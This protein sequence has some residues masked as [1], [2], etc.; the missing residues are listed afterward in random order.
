MK[1]QILVAVCALATAQPFLARETATTAASDNSGITNT[2]GQLQPGDT[3]DS[4][5]GTEAPASRWLT[6][7]TLSFS[8]RWR[9]VADSHGYHLFDAGQERALIDGKLKLDGE[10][11]Y[12]VN[13]HVST[14]RYF[15]WAYADSIGAGF[16]STAANSLPY[17]S[18][19]QLANLYAAFAADPKGYADFSSHIASRGWR[20]GVR[21]FYF[22]GTPIKQITFEYG[23]LGIERGANTE[24]TSY[25]EDG[26]L[27]GERLRIKDPQ[28]LFF[29]QVAVTYGYMGDYFTPNFF[30]RADRLTQSNYHQFLVDKRFGRRFKAS[31]D[32][33]WENRTDTIR[34]AV[35]VKMPET[36][37]LD[38]AR[39][40][41]YQRVN[42]VTLQGETFGSG[43]GFAITGS[44]NIAKR[45]LLEGGYATIDRSYAALAGDRVIATGFAFNGDSWGLGSR[46]YT[47]ANLK[48]ND[49][50]TL[51]G[52]YTHS[53]NETYY[54]LTRQG[55][56][57]G[58]TV[59]FKNL[60]NNKLHLGIASKGGVDN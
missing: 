52:F 59:D 32:Y 30:D 23:G 10:G 36:R 6:L 51:F 38:A 29:D 35:L 33:T 54:L 18:P 55:M 14:G 5:Q 40:E 41:L 19:T 50:F 12:T 46:I 34:E 25:D 28:H 31:A 15:N 53:V 17:Y 4:S 39:L 48:L 7:N 45:F 27:A 60:L 37:I 11:K 22:S 20:L 3:S 16:G 57:F 56:N 8:Y 44:K 42:A 24:I 26:Y 1:K 9:D 2:P 43:N 47:R 58:M 49:Y 21:Q 13:F